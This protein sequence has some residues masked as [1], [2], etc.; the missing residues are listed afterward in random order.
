MRAPLAIGHH[1]QAAHV[2]ASG[3]VTSPAQRKYS[4]VG[5]YFPYTDAKKGFAPK[6]ETLFCTTNFVVGRA[7]FEPATNGLKVEEIF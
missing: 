3:R 2:V 1:E 5:E 4:P 6:R 7:G